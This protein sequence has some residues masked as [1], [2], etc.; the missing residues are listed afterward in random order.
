MFPAW[1]TPHLFMGVFFSILGRE[2][3]GKEITIVAELLLK[4]AKEARVENKCAASAALP[5]ARYA[6]KA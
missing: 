1:C 2:N 3:Y 6:R 4:D 5:C